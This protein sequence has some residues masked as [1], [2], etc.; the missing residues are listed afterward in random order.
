M[1]KHVYVVIIIVNHVYVVV[2]IFNHVIIDML[3]ALLLF[4]HS[5]VRTYG[6][7]YYM[8]IIMFDSY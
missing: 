8:F 3:E 6:C 1:F 7:Y 2:I 5:Y 4:S